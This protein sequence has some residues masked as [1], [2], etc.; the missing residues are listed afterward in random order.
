MA[1]TATLIKEGVI[2]GSARFKVYQVTKDGSST[3]VAITPG[4][5]FGHCT[6]SELGYTVSSGVF[7]LKEANGT[8]D[9]L[10]DV[11]FWSL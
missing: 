7:T 10:Y 5:G 4:V 2:S 8:A 3:T 6:G 9:D 1:T 11:I